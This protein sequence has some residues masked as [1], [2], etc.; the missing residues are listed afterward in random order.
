MA[1]NIVFVA[2]FFL[3]RFNFSEAQMVPAMFV[4]G[5]SLVDVGNNN[6]LDLSVAKATLPYYGIDLPTK[7]PAGR[8]TNG[9]NAADFLGKWIESSF[10][11]YVCVCVCIIMHTV[12]SRFD[13]YVYMF[14]SVMELLI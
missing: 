13:Q 14:L 9:M 3:L 6:F 2:S 11:L 10:L 12:P 8:F 7:K 1:Y 5:D 4:F